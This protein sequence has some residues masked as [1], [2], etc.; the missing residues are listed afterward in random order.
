MADNIM[1]NG[2]IDHR[3]KNV[4]IY[5]RV[6]VNDKGSGIEPTCNTVKATVIFFFNSHK[7][8]SCINRNRD[9]RVIISF[10]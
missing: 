6:I 10:N 3:S 9:H 1:I 2:S 8:G 7:I 4:H 5:K